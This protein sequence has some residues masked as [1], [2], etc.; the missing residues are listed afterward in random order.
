M[1]RGGAKLSGC[2]PGGGRHGNLKEAKA[3]LDE[4]RCRSRRSVT[5][6][7]IECPFGPMH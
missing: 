1:N 5:L 7:N 2:W 6:K 3:L 4:L